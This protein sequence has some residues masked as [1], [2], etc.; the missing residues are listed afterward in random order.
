MLDDPLEVHRKKIL[1]KLNKL[2]PFDTSTELQTM[3]LNALIEA[4][5]ETRDIVAGTR[6]IQI[7]KETQSRIYTI[8]ESMRRGVDMTHKETC[9]VIAIQVENVAPS[10]V[11]KY[12]Y[13]FLNKDK[14]DKVSPN[15][16]RF[17]VS[18][19]EECESIQH[20]IRTNDVPDS[21]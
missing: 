7:N 20:Y 19:D 8:W 21:L 17:F 16:I 12:I 11:S 4:T 13:S 9:E 6:Y 14:K 15:Q 2:K 5:K 18:E 10:T 1:R 3:L